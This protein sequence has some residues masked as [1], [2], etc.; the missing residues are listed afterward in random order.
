MASALA[1]SVD[2]CGGQILYI[3]TVRPCH[4]FLV[5]V[6]VYFACELSQSTLHL[7]GLVML[8]VH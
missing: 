3:L 6:C 4:G 2:A 8:F 1:R 7:L 5:C